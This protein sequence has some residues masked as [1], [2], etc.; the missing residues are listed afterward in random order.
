MKNCVLFALL[1][2]CIHP[3]RSQ[4]LEYGPPVSG[5]QVAVSASNNF[6]AIGSANLLQY[7]IR[8]SSTNTV[9]FLNTGSL[10][11]DFT[12]LVLVDAL[13]NSHDLRPHHSMR[14][15]F[16]NVPVPVKP[17]DSCHTEIRIV[18]SKSVEEGKYW[19]KTKRRFSTAARQPPA[20]MQEV[21]SAPIE[22]RLA[23]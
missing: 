21:A 22:V 18:P 16:S 20:A 23:K 15:I 6:L 5:V 19:L 3:L 4:T 9:Y 11:D 14:A 2:L 13:G 1:C 7:W 12:V 10:E 17:G 8:N